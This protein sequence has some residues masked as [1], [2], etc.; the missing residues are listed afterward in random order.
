VVLHEPVQVPLA[1]ALHIPEHLALQLAVTVRGVQLPVQ[2]P[3]TRN[4]QVEMSEMT[5]SPPLV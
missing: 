3:L 1:E 4:A 5:T 2:P